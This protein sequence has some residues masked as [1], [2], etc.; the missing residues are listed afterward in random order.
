MTF[1]IIKSDLPGLMS[2]F[3]QRR[4]QTR[5]ANFISNVRILVPVEPPPPESFLCPPLGQYCWTGLR[6][7]AWQVAL[8]S[9]NLALSRSSK[10]THVRHLR[11]SRGVKPEAL[12]LQVQILDAH[13]NPAHAA[14][15][16]VERW[17][18]REWE[19]APP[20]PSSSSTSLGNLT[21]PPELDNRADH[22][23]VDSGITA[24]APYRYHGYKTLRALQLP[25][26]AAFSV[27]DAI[28][29]VLAVNSSSNKYHV[30][31]R[32]CSWCVNGT[33]I[34]IERRYGGN[35]IKGKPTTIAGHLDHRRI[36][37]DASDVLENIQNL[38]QDNLDVIAKLKTLEE[39]NYVRV[40]SSTTD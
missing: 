5:I 9:N 35:T 8:A 6:P 19:S 31:D 10:V 40:I 24:R 11:S 38:W 36:S 17:C 16:L 20:S 18:L 39:V 32:N 14:W 4:L 13:G 27:A 25:D 22:I 21:S 2:E 29:L 34:I 7:W 3:L 15:L 33:Y 28:A 30:T 37:P 26:D 23:G 12:Q 1:L